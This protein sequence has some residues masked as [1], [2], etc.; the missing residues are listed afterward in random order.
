[1]WLGRKFERYGALRAVMTMIL[2]GNGAA[3]KDNM[4]PGRSVSRIRRPN[5]P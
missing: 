1:V 4:N 2:K 5:N 3:P